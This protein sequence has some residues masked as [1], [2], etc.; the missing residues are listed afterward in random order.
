MSNRGKLIIPCDFSSNSASTHMLTISSVLYILINF[1]LSYLT[2]YDEFNTLSLCSINGF[3]FKLLI[4]VKHIYIHVRGILFSSQKFKNIIFYYL[5]KLE[6]NYIEL[7]DRLLLLHDISLI[8]YT[9]MIY[10][11]Y[12][13]YLVRIWFSTHICLYAFV[14]NL[15][16]FLQDLLW[17]RNF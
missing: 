6:D 7:E 9:H 15:N 12:V 3:F 5:P 14:V 2:K 10:V 13:P 11:C 17:Y 16:G 4:I 8:S 1:N